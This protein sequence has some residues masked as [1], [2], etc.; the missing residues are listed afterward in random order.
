MGNALGT[1]KL[2]AGPVG[3]L[4]LPEASPS[5]LRWGIPIVLVLDLRSCLVIW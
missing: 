2:E 4:T 1:A 5:Y 3:S